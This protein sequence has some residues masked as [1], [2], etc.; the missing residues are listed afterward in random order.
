M[1]DFPTIRMS[2]HVPSFPSS[3][4]I[5]KNKIMEICICAGE[6]LLWRAANKIGGS[7]CAHK[8]HQEGTFTAVSF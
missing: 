1:E 4:C 5:S 3:N 7:A 6:G 2:D 8:P